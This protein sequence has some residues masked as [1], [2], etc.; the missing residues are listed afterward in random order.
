[1]FAQQQLLGTHLHALCTRA[2]H[3]HALGY[4]KLDFVVYCRERRLLLEGTLGNVA[5]AHPDGSRILQMM[6]LWA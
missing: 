2:V 4:F 6:S 1:M 5:V 3:T